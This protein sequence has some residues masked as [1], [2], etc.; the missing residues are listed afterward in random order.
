MA[1]PE[2][3]FRFGAVSASVFANEIDTKDGKAKVSN[4]S[5]QRT[6]RDKNGNFQNSSS[7]R[8]NDIPKAILALSKAYEYLVAGEGADQ[9]AA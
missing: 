2:K 9:N 3:R 5:L 1:Q 8:A 7:F 6:Y 4:V